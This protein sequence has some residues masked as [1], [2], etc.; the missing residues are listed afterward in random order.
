M[1][2]IGAK[3]F[4]E[5]VYGKQLSELNEEEKQN[6]LNASK[7]LAGIASGVASGGNGL[8]L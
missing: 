2:E 3:V 1:S 8:R 5:T 7:A 6:L 4:V